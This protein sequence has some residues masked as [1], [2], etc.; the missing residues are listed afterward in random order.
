M[1]TPQPLNEELSEIVQRSREM[2]A[3]RVTGASDAPNDVEYM[4]IPDSRD[5]RIGSGGATIQ[6]LGALMKRTLFRLRSEV[7]G[8]HLEGW[9]NNQRVLM[10]HSGGDSRRLPQYSLAGKLFTALPAVVTGH[11]Y[12]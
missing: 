3:E 10:V 12:Y 7:S 6:A 5:E 11:R 1:N 8:I 2:Y 9:W 4:V